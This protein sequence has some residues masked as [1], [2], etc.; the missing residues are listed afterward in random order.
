[1]VLYEQSKAKQ[2]VSTHLYAYYYDY[3]TVFVFLCDASLGLLVVKFGMHCRGGDIVLGMY[4]GGYVCVCDVF[5]ASGR[6][7]YSKVS[8]RL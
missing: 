5:F 8:G 3:Y 1:M 7:I 6:A 4:L 2:S